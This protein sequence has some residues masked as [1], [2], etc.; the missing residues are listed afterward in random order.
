MRIVHKLLLATLLPAL[1]IWVV[2]M[3]A[4]HVSERSMRQ[5]IE[6]TSMTRA[7]AVMDE[8][9]RIVQARTADWKAYSRSDLAQQVLVASNQAIEALEDPAATIEERDQAWRETPPDET[10]RFMRLLLRNPLS[11][12]L[13]QR[14]NKLNEGSGYTIF[15]EVFF[16]NRFGVNAAQT[17]RTSDYRQDDETWWKQAFEHDVFIGDVMLDESAGVY[18]VDICLRV[19]DENGSPLG[20][21]KAVMNIQEVFSVIDTRVGRYR[22]DERLVLFTAEGRVIRAS[23]DETKPLSDGSIYFK[24]VQLDA[25]HAND[26]YYRRDDET[27]EKYLSA[28]ALSRGYG[29]FEGLGWITMDERRESVVFAPVNRLRNQI[30]WISSLATL[31]T[32]LIGGATAISF[33]KRLGQ[34]TDATV[35]IG[36][37]ELDITVATKGN[38][39]VAEL[40]R[41]FNRMGSE[42][43]QTHHDLTLARDAARDANKAKSSFLANMSHEIR[44]PM[45]GIIGMGELLAS[46]QL[47]PEQ[48]DYLNMIQQSADSLLRLLNDILDFSKI[49]AGRLELEEI[50]FSLRDCIEKTGQALAIRA[51]EKGLEMACRIAPDLPDTFLGDPGRIRQIIVNLAGNAI[52]FTQQGEVVVDVTCR[53]R[54]ENKIRLHFRVIDTGVGIPAEKQTKIFEAFGQAD[55]STTREFGGTGLGLTISSQLVAM[56]NGE[57][58]VESEVDKGTTFHFTI[59]LTVQNDLEKQHR[60]E[61]LSMHPMHVLIVDDNRTNRRIFEEVLKSWNMETVS[62]DAAPRGVKGVETSSVVR[63]PIRSGAA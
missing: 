47:S 41:H 51:A 63:A 54:S 56:M 11:R 58:W 59:E 48:R 7:T 32:L 43:Q 53:S 23:N 28:F 57:I 16:T 5:A 10:S 18:S 49:E 19:D 39:E 38:D 17:S 44:T 6:A 25:D 60:V 36:R 29:D 13:R 27:G 24:D 52:K 3:Y 42:L 33:S 50:E 31:A 61:E 46:S 4:T 62:T 21:L 1:L 30:I 26:V 15:G 2:G 55:A 20:V 14:L 34:L 12:D 8:I 9:D 40:A 22:D 35:A 45:N 37:G